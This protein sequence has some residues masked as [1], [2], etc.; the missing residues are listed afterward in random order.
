MEANATCETLRTQRD[1]SLYLQIS[2]SESKLPLFQIADRLQTLSSMYLSTEEK[3][4]VYLIQTAWE[5]LQMES[6]SALLHVSQF[7]LKTLANPLS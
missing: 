6:P 3:L 2:F 4:I 5:K 1:L 7:L